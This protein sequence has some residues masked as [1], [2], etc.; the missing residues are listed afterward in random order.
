MIDDAQSYDIIIHDIEK[1]AEELLYFII[2]KW[3]KTEF[4]FG[5]I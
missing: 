4:K 2:P 3:K 1:S 5:N